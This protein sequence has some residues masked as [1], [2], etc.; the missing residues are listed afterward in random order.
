[1]SLIS[2]GGWIFVD[3]EFHGSTISKSSLQ[4][5][6]DNEFKR[7]LIVNGEEDTTYSK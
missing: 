1:M 4:K 3:V 5:D 6:M 2:Q 7:K